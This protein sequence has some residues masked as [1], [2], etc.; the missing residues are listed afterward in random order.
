M[1]ALYNGIYACAQAVRVPGLDLLIANTRLAGM[2]ITELIRQVRQAKPS[3]PILHLGEPL[4]ESFLEVVNL[5][6]P[7]TDEQLLDHVLKLV[8]RIDGHGATLAI[9]SASANSLANSG[10]ASVQG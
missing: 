10:P 7:W 1:F 9:R 4:A 6:E 3:L 8:N 2:T 5:A